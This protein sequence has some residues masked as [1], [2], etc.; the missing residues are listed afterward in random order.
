MIVSIHHMLPISSFSSCCCWYCYCCLLLNLAKQNNFI[1]FTQSI[2]QSRP[3]LRSVKN[4]SKKNYLIE[5]SDLITQKSLAVSLVLGE[6]SNEAQK[7][8]NY[9]FAHR[10]SVPIGQIPISTAAMDYVNRQF[11]TISSH[12]SIASV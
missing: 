11:Y 4:Q 10:I 9:L 6:S 12:N 1:N 7:L 2:V 3:V 8:K 5:S